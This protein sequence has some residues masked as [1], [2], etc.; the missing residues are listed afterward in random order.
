MSDLP[1]TAF[2][3]SGGASLGAI[4]VGMLRALYEREVAPDLIVGT[5]VGAING[6][7]IASRPPTAATAQK[8]AHVWHEIGRGQVFPL[9]PLTGFLGFFGA[10]DHFVS[11]ESLRALID[12]NIEFV[13][14]EQA[15][16]PFHVIATDLLSGREVRL[17]H[18]D[19]L[20]AVMASAAIP[21]V[22]APVEWDGRQLIDGGVSNNA[23]IAH[24]I[25]LGAE[26]VY[27]LPTGSACDLPDP[28]HGAL[29]MLLH[30]MS[31]LVMHRL[32]VE[33][34]ALREHAELIVLPPPCPPATTPIDFSHTD[35]LIRQGY[36]GSQAYLDALTGGWGP[37]PSSVAMYN[38]QPSPAPVEA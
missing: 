22:F 24:A 30:A 12:D 26:R 4:Q 1:K 32:L 34:E 35:E 27:V 20:E 23:P 38:H 6:A 8:L 17:S 2:V 29:A 25:E 31:V 11:D 15:P 21:G 19:A 14:L 10:R 5:S 9:N 36:A 33:V 28:P 37:A 13:E 7:F 3:L 18:G 16:I